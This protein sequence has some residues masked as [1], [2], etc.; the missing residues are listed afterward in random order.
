MTWQE[1]TLKPIQSKFEI[2]KVDCRLTE[3]IPYCDHKQVDSTRK[4]TTVTCAVSVMPSKISEPGWQFNWLKFGLSFGL[5]NGLR[6]HFD[7]DPL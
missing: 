6:F 5:K 2:P 7:F 3:K 1:C 4:R